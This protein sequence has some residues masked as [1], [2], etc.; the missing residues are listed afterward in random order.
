[1][2]TFLLAALMAAPFAL[3]AEPAAAQAIPCGEPYAVR[4]GDTMMRIARRAYGGDAGL[5]VLLDANADLFARRD[6]SLIEVGELLTVPCPGEEAA[7]APQEPPEPAAI[8]E[9]APAEAETERPEVVDAAPAAPEAPEPAFIEAAPAE[10]AP[11]AEPEPEIAEAPPPEPERRQP[12]VAETP[13]AEAAEPEPEP[14]PEITEVSPVE[15]Q[16]ERAA[17][18]PATPSP[19]LATTPAA[20]LARWRLDGPMAAVAQ[21][22]AAEAMGA[23]S[24][25]LLPLVRPDCPAGAGDARCAAVWSEPIVETALVALSRVAEPTPNAAA[26]RVCLGAAA[27]QAREPVAAA[28]C[29]A[30]LLDGRADL[31]LLEAGAADAALAALGPDAGRLAELPA[32]TRRVTLRAAAPADD[33][34]AVAAVAALDAA[35]TRLRAGG[36]WFAALETALSAR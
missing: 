6:P 31:A 26:A 13:P 18:P 2:P 35:L 5:R 23:A 30:A 4:R 29:L 7:A 1:M 9:T 19:Q 10:P 21:A 11:E 27:P 28:D 16:A 33:A 32:L 8:A 36:G 20:A 15:P 34:M 17:A 24:P 22:L 3:S 12:I 25:P 14:E